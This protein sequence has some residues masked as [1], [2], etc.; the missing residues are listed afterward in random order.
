MSD[1]IKKNKESE[2][3]EDRRKMLK[4]AAALATAAVAGGLGASAAEGQT[5][6][7]QPRKVEAGEMVRLQPSRV[8]Q[9]VE[10]R[11]LSQPLANLSA[12][13]PNIKTNEMRQVLADIEEYVQPIL[14]RSGGQVSDVNITV[15]G[16]IT[17]SG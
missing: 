1:E 2:V 13:N 16:T 7:A 15:E 11:R 6:R 8:A 12:V 14:D 3:S 4:G 5:A 17:V 10:I 9:S